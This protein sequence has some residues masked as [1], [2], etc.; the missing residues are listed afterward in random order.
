[1]EK[2]TTKRKKITTTTPIIITRILRPTIKSVNKKG[3]TKELSVLAINQLEDENEI[4]FSDKN[5]KEKPS[6]E[7]IKSSPSPKPR[8]T[9]TISNSKFH[10]QPKNAT[11]TTTPY[12]TTIFTP[13]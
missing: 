13:G 4:V 8:T 2:T 10:R 5:R 7:R 1:M 3:I 11:L 6:K 9:P 12:T